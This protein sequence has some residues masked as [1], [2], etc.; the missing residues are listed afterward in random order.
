MTRELP[1]GLRRNPTDLRS[2]GSFDHVGRDAGSEGLVTGAVLADLADA[3]ERIVAA[4]A[5]LKYVTRMSLFEVRHPQRFFQFGIAERNMLTAAAGMA[6]CGLIPYVATFACFSG[7]LGYEAIRTDHAYPNLPVRVIAT[8][9]GIGMGFFATSHHAT[10]DISALRAV[11][12]LTILSPPDPAATE[13]LLRSTVDLPGP[14]YFRLGRGRDRRVYDAP[15]EHYGPGAPPRVVIEGSDVLLVS[16]GTMVGECL[17]AARQLA[18]DGGV[19]PTVLDVH[20]LKPFDAAAVAGHAGRHRV[21]VTVEEH[22]VQGGL[23]TLV[24]E[25]L[26]EAGVGVPVRTHGLLDE[27]A[28]IGPP[29]HLYRYYGLDPDGIATVVRRAADESG[30]P[31]W[32]EDDRQRVLDAYASR[33]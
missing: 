9:A 33:S 23:G 10:E 28:L 11:A 12:G 31:L 14:I 30:A 13:S 25:A 3:D 17:E 22:N 26:A 18:A 7:I 15:P 2:P 29:T 4:C 19:S 5:D 27:F 24:R 6:S 8:H 16:T 21:V 1:P 20:T 32:S